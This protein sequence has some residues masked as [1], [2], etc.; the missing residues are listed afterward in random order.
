MLVSRDEGEAKGDG[1]SPGGDRGDS[2]KRLFAFSVVATLGAATLAVAD[3]VYASRADGAYTPDWSFMKAVPE[4][5]LLWGNYLGL[6]AM[7]AIVL[8]VWAIYRTLASVGSRWALPLLSSGVGTATIGGAQ[9][10]T[11][12]YVGAIHRFAD[13]MPEASAQAARAFVGQQ[14]QIMFNAVGLLMLV[15]GVC[16]IGGVLSKKT[17]YP[18]WALACAPP[19]ASLVFVMLSKAP[20]VGAYLYPACGTLGLTAMFAAASVVLSKQARGTMPDRA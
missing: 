2:A 1:R 17:P 16:F 9:H 10:M 8:G 3:V 11:A 7:P 19:V 14:W 15:L 6:A 12:M 4:S 20:V 18:K 5:R 13:D